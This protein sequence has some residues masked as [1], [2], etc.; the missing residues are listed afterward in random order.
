M[1]GP[2]RVSAVVRSGCLLTALLLPLLATAEDGALAAK[3]WLDQMASAVSNLTYRGTLIYLRRDQV[4]S[5]RIYHRVDE[6][7]MRER[8]VALNGSP[9]EILR[10]NNS[11]R[12]IFPD[13]RSVLIDTRIA[14]RLFPVIPADLF[15]LSEGR[16]EL[17]LDGADRVAQLEAQVVRIAAADNFR[18]GYR[19]WLEK[20][21]GMLLKSSLINRQGQAI[22]QVLFTDIEIGAVISDQDLLPDITSDGYV[23]VALPDLKTSTPPDSAPRWRVTKLPV[24]FEPLAQR[25]AG[26]LSHLT[27][28][29][30]LAVVSVYVEPAGDGQTAP[31][32]YSRVGAMNILSQMRGGFAVTAVGEV[33]PTTLEMMVSSVAQQPGFGPARA[34]V[35]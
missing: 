11:V 25:R 14:E 2:D 12:C 34:N 35:P 24:G 29:D 10:D 20:N 30:G 4:D 7:G 32:G 33:P 16:Y 21:T 27:F 15:S 8:L 3:R 9:R 13:R 5:L 19:L 17:S 23:E 1:P 26:P 18:F 22:E 6:T 28:S 31:R